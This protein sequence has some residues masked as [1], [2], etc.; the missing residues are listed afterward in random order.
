MCRGLAAHDGITKT[1]NGSSLSEVEKKKKGAKIRDREK[2][3]RKKI[4]VLF[5]A[6]LDP[7][8]VLHLFQSCISYA[9]IA[10]KNHG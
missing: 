8:G 7:G 4:A 1:R 10:P 9:Y 5:K 2:E 3:K 6:V